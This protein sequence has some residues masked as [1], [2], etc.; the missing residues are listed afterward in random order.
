MYAITD[1]TSFAHAFFA[2]INCAAGMTVIWQTLCSLNSMNRKT[3]SSIKWAVR[4]TAVGALSMMLHPPEP[5]L[6]G[7]GQLA[8]LIGLASCFIFGRRRRFCLA[9]PARRWDDCGGEKP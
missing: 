8:L 7:V 4:L 5:D 6:G 1:S 2:A 9:C 3:Q